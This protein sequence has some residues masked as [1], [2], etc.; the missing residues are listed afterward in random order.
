MWMNPQKRLVE[1]WIG[2]HGAE[3][4]IDT[5]INERRIWEKLSACVTVCVRAKGQFRTFTV[6]S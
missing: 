6:D 1:I 4:Y 3:H 5:A 2:L